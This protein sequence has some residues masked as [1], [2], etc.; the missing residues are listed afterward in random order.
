MEPREYTVGDDVGDRNVLSSQGNTMDYTMDYDHHQENSMDD[1][2][3]SHEARNASLSQLQDAS[4]LPEQEDEDELPVLEFARSTGI[5]RNHEL[6][7]TSV[8]D[9]LSMKGNLEH[10]FS[11]G[12]DHEYLPQLNAHCDINLDERLFVGKGAAQLLTCVAQNE[13]RESIYG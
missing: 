6:D 9:L 10:Q 7:D 11:I 5:A 1:Y 2:T 3:M 4:G 12:L 13:S 8:D